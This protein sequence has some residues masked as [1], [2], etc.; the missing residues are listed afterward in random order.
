LQM[1]P[2]GFDG[3]EDFLFYFFVHFFLVAGC[4]PLASGS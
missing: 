1:R 4:W 3:V 2:D